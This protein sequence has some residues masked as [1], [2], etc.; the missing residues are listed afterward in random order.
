MVIHSSKWYVLPQKQCSYLGHAGV[1]CPRILSVLI[2]PSD[3]Q[4]TL[5]S[6]RLGEA[7]FHVGGLPFCL[8]GL[9][10]GPSQVWSSCLGFVVLQK[11]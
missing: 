11:I 8:V 2:R 4:R 3:N 7:I 9:A 1:H 6:R 5:L 10:S